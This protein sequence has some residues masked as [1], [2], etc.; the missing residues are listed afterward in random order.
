MARMSRLARL[1]RACWVRVH[2]IVLRLSAARPPAKG[3]LRADEALAIRA[4]SV[5]GL[6]LTPISLIAALASCLDAKSL[7]L[8]AS[9]LGLAVGYGSVVALNRFRYHRLARWTLAVSGCLHVIVANTAFGARHGFEFYLA[10]MVF[11]PIVLTP[12]G[13]SEKAVAYTLFA[14]AW[15]VVAVLQWKSVPW[16]HVARGPEIRAYYASLAFVSILVGAIVISS[17]VR[18]RRLREALELEQ[19]RSEG[20]VARM[21]PPAIAER[22]KAGATTIA[23]SHDCATVLFADLVGFTRLSQSTP[24]EVLVDLLDELFGRFDLLARKHGVTKVKTIGDCYMAVVGVV[25]PCPDQASAMVDLALDLLGAV[26][27]L[28]QDRGYSLELRVGVAQG[29]VVSGV[30]GKDRPMFDIWGD[31]VNLASRMESTGA[32]GAVHVTGTMADRLRATHRL[33]A[34]GPIS[35]KGWTEA[36]ET[37]L[38]RGRLETAIDTERG[39]L[40]SA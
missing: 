10:G 26:S 20:L 4:V 25:E 30:I 3:E 31:T 18:N 7:A 33:E 21:L 17:E 39:R 9:N 12:R 32:P 35:I 23:E 24:P 37:F 11:A 36:F 15:A 1:P 29:P 22:L 28:S 27:R 14:V 34:R 38:V 2:A 19:A 6:M 16:V 40:Q 13:K 5:A 8:G